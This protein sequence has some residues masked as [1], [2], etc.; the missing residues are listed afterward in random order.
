M[1]LAFGTSKWQFIMKIS[2]LFNFGKKVKRWVRIFHAN[3]ESAV[4]FNGFA[5]NWFKQP[6]LVRQDCPLSPYFVILGAEISVIAQTSSDVR[7]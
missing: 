2:K 7:N 1:S 6:R 5:T 4:M 3:S